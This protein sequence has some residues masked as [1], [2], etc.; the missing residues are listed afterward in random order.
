MFSSGIYQR[1]SKKLVIRIRSKNYLAIIASLDDMLRLVWD[2]V[3]RKACH[4][5]KLLVKMFAIASK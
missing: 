3:T 5:I 4:M 1:I 2:N